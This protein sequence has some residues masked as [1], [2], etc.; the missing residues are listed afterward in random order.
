MVSADDHG[1]RWLLNPFTLALI[2]QAWPELIGFLA[3]NHWTLPH[4]THI[5]AAEGLTLLLKEADLVVDLV[6]V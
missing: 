4:V 3:G 5:D 2:V 1:V 6:M